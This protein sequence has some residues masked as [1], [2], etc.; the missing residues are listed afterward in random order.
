MPR[1]QLDP[2]R[3]NQIDERIMRRGQMLMHRFNHR[4]VGMGAG[5]L[6]NLRMTRP[7]FLFPRPKATGHDDLAIFP[8]GLP[9]RIERLFNRSIDEAA[10]IDDNQVGI[11]IG[12]HQVIAFRSKL[13]HDLFAIDQ[14]LGAPETNETDA[15]RL[16]H[17]AEPMGKRHIVGDS[18]P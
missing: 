15:G 10:G 6:E 16:G 5:D 17:G 8:Q 14:C 12:W 11:A 7:N 18:M 4:L 9:D 2:F 3:R 13:R 1:S